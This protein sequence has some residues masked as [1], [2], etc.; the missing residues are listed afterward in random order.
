MKTKLEA[1]KENI[2]LAATVQA[3]LE[4]KE[5]QKFLK[6]E[7]E[8]KN[9][10]DRFHQYING[11]LQGCNDINVEINTKDLSYD[12]IIAFKCNGVKY[13]V[14]IALESWED[15]MSD[16]SP[17]QKFY[18]CILG[19]Y[20]DSWVSNPKISCDLPENYYDFLHDKVI[21]ER[22]LKF[23]DGIYNFFAI[24]SLKCDKM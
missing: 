18:K 4:L 21:V 6:K 15:R 24:Q 9:K 3:N 19:L 10:I 14:R 20:G 7:E 5:R 13:Y 17:I 11:K 1:F 12:N 8:T 2:K 23:V 16:E 22:I